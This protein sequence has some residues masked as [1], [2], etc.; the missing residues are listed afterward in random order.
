MFLIGNSQFLYRDLMRPFSDLYNR[1]E[2]E[3]QQQFDNLNLNYTIA[4]AQWVK[5]S[6]FNLRKAL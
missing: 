6:V 3:L 1:F 4:F 5:Q 2:Y